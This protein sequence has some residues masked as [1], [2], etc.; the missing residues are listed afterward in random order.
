MKIKTPYTLAAIFAVSLL[1]SGCS[2]MAAQPAEP[3]AKPTESQTVVDCSKCKKAPAPVAGGAHTHPA[4]P[5]CTDSTTH[6]HPF[7]NANHKHAYS[8]KG[9]IKK[10]KPPKGNTP[11]QP[12]APTG[13][14]NHTHPAIPGCT[15]SITHSHPYTNANHNHHYSCKGG[16]KPEKQ[17]DVPQVKAKGN[18]KGPVQIDTSVMKTYKKQ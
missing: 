11:K 17:I 16:N 18:Y 4:I 15:D 12:T 8:C 9:G 3:A 2:Q 10:V 14:W 5:G 7:T 13:K 6:T 1:A